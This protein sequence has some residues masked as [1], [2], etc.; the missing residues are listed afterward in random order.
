MEGMSHFT[1][2]YWRV[3]QWLNLRTEPQ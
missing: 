2:L 3:A 1:K